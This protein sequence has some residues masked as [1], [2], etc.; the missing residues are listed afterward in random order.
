VSDMATGLSALAELAAQD[1]HELT[2]AELREQLLDI[3]RVIRSAEGVRASRLAVF[4]TR[5]VGAADNALSTAAWLRHR[6]QLDYGEAKQKVQTA[7][8]LRDLPQTAAALSAGQVG[9]RQA[10]AIG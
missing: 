10:A 1:P 4:D 8:A 6:C 2:D 5:D 3:E 7:R 9:Y